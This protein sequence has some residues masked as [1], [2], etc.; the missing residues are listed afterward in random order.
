MAARPSRRWSGPC[1][2][3]R[4]APH[5]ACCLRTSIQPAAVLSPSFRSGRRCLFVLCTLRSALSRSIEDPPQ[6]KHDKSL[7]WTSRALENLVAFSARWLGG[8]LLKRFHDRLQALIDHRANGNRAAFTRE[9]GFGV[10]AFKNWFTKEER[11]TLPQFL[12][13]GLALD[14]MPADLL[15]EE[16]PAPTSSSG[17]VSGFRSL[18]ERSRTN[19][20]T[21][22]SAL[23]PARRP[24]G[25]TK[26]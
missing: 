14:L 9:L 4:Y 7:T 5:T 21:G 24:K 18:A 8:G 11:P 25:Q 12:K 19:D 16:A 1:K 15:D 2:P 20:E 13:L 26:P 6:G 23:A 17:S 3:T 10:G 22:D